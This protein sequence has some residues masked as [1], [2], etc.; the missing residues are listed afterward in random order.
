MR[1]RAGLVIAV[2]LA[3]L[4][5]PVWTEQSA[6]REVHGRSVIVGVTDADDAPIKGLT[7]ADFV[8]R[9]DTIAREITSVSPAPLPTHVVLLIDDTQVTQPVITYLRTALRV[10][11]RRFAAAATSA[12]PDDPPM[13]MEL[14]TF[15][16]RPTKRV[17]FTP[18][19]PEIEKGIDRIFHITGAGS[20][21][22]DA[23][24]EITQDF[25]KREAARP[26]IVSFTDEAGPEFSTRTARDIESALQASGAQLWNVTLQQGPQPVLD[27][28]GRERASVIGDVTRASGGYSKAVLTPQALDTAFGSIA[29][30]LLSRYLV[31]YGR[32]ES[33]IPPSRLEVTVKR[34]GANVRVAKWLVGK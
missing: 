17:P 3:V 25:R 33:L 4:S 27:T 28:E 34:P 29:D 26:I 31:I 24:T 22:L 30:Q 6:Q 9:E 7:P 8:V 13:Q 32:P 16:E 11:T 5:V 1:P 20:Y 12:N 23:I 18:N 21:F 2:A 10:F 14:F 19:I 15:G